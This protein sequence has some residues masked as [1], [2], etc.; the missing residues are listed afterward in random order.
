MKQI[1]SLASAIV[2]FIF[3][4]WQIAQDGL[5]H[6]VAAAVAGTAGMILLGSWLTMEIGD[7]WNKDKEKN[8]GNADQG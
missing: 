6:N 8:D 7:Y 1:Y 5:G 4:A 2:M 3:G